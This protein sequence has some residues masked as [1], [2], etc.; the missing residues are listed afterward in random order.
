MSDKIK[1]LAQYCGIRFGSFG[2]P[3]VDSELFLQ[4]FANEIIIHA[5][6]IADKEIAK[7]KKNQVKP[8]TLIK[9]AFE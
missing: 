3:I 4:R 1:N 2:E 7:P 9:A 5:G 6:E 8:S